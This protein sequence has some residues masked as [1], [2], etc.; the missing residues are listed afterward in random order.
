MNRYLIRVPLRSI[1][2]WRPP[3]QIQFDPTG[4]KTIYSTQSANTF[5]KIFA[6]LNVG[7]IGIHTYL[8]FTEYLY[9]LVPGR[10]GLLITYVSLN[11]LGALMAFSVEYVSRKFAKTI[12]LKQ[13]GRQLLLTFHSAF[14]SFYHTET[15]N[16]ADIQKIEEFSREHFKITTSEGV[17]FLISHSRNEIQDE[18]SKI[19]FKKV[20]A[21]IT[22]NTIGTP[23]PNRI[24]RY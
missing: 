6:P 20:L 22:I 12:S 14:T 17:K 24:R 13:N 5:L 4:K 10:F 19:L 18:E 1:S 3:F 16:I 8:S 23:M 21:G 11:A 9:P 7:F 15:I 2:E